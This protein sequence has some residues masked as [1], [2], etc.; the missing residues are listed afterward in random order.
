MEIINVIGYALFIGLVWLLIIFYWK[1]KEAKHRKIKLILN[2][3]NPIVIIDGKAININEEV[4]KFA[5]QEENA[6]TSEKAKNEVIK[7]I[8]QAHTSP[9]NAENLLNEV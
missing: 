4:K 3:K 8:K 5:E 6:K 1:N 2:H 7:E 9:I